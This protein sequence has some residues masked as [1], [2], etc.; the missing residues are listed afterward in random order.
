M[1]PKT[2]SILGKDCPR[3]SNLDSFENLGV[4][5]RARLNEDGY[6]FVFRK[7]FF[8]QFNFRLIGRKVNNQAGIFKGNSKAPNPSRSIFG[9]LCSIS[10]SV[11]EVCPTRRGIFHETEAN[12]AN[13]CL[14]VDCF[15][16]KIH[17]SRGGGPPER[18][19]RK[20]RQ[21]PTAPSTEKTVH[22]ALKK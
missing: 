14:V 3:K 11:W 12:H 20:T 18:P 19:Q 2:A 6:I 9:F 22:G 10:F 15:R 1:P 21:P 7:Y 17:Q 5:V 8:M 4:L 16:G 13:L